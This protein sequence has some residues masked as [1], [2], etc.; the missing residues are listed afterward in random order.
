MHAIATQSKHKSSQPPT[1]F[2]QAKL[3]V[4]Q[5]GDRFEQ[6]ADAMADHVVGHTRQAPSMTPVSGVQ[7]KCAACSA[8]EEM[9]QKMSLMR[10]SGDGSTADASGL[11]SQ[12]SSAKG[13]GSAM[14]R[15][16]LN[17]MNQAFGHDFSGVRVHTDRQAVQMSE[18]LNARAFTH[19]SDVFF[20]KGEYSPNT[21]SGKHLLAHELTHVV[22]QGGG[23]TNGIQ[24]AEGET[25]CDDGVKTVTV[26]I[27]SFNG[28][29]R[30]PYPDLAEAN[31][32]FSP[33]CVRFV[34][35]KG[36]SVDPQYSDPLVGNNTTF[37]RGSNQADTTEEQNL[38]P[39]IEGTF[40][41]NGRIKVLYFEGISPGARGT[42]HPPFNSTP[43]TLNYVYMTNFAA[44]RSLAHEFGHILLNGSFHHLPAD[45]LMHPS[46]TA[47]DSKL[48]PSQCTTIRNNI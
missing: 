30:S 13:R 10:K 23:A 39:D 22:Q 40:G 3:K 21:S 20:N 37:N 42:S 9:G 5:P 19:G 7:R 44:L 16:T 36:A 27:L 41:L 6:E 43:L 14:P 33:C 18:S 34:L 8:Q 48:T 1:P 38:I 12:L 24:R 11:T 31:R 4:N 2:F 32:I 47:T 25:A 35:G 46:N 28:S 45:N 15:Q 26:D 29:T 17:S